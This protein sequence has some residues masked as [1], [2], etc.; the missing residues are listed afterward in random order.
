MADYLLYDYWR[1]SAAF[2]VR[3]ALGW[4]RLTWDRVSIDLRHGAQSS[5][6]YLARNPQ[7][8][9]PLLVSGDQAISQSLAIMEYLEEVHP[10]PPLLP[11]SPAAR[12]EVR[13]AAMVVACD[14]HPVNNLR[15]LRYLR[16]PLGLDQEE[17]DNWARHWIEA[18]LTALEQFS[19]RYG[20]NMLWGD[21]VTMADLCLLPQLYNARRVGTDFGPFPRLVAIEARLRPADFVRGAHPDEH[22][23]RSDG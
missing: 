8:L 19:C 16:D 18:G 13:S 4:K 14:V 7:G 10:A 21:T 22:P 11:G 5:A 12:A 3:L 2:R 6:D 9:V 1:S 23:D 15:I 17:I 20:G